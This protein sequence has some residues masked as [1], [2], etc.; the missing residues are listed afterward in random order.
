MDVFNTVP[1]ELI[2][3][4]GLVIIALFAILFLV[5]PAW[6]CGGIIVM[7]AL[8]IL[9]LTTNGLVAIG[10]AIVITIVFLFLK[11]GSK[12]D[13]DISDIGDGNHITINR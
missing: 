10:G 6:G 4:F 2:C 11:F 12:G 13:I 1:P 9:G 8:L 3:L 7:L 5:K